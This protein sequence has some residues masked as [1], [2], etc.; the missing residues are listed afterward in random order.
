LHW[1]LANRIVQAA[2]PSQKH[3]FA[4]HHDAAPAGVVAIANRMVMNTISKF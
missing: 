4:V 3:P 2:A 1:A